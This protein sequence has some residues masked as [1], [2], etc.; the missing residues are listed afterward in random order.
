[1]KRRICLLL[2]AVLL[3]SLCGCGLSEPEPQGAER[4]SQEEPAC[5]LYA[6]YVDDHNAAGQLIRRT[7]LTVDGQ[8]EGWTQYEYDEDGRMAR[9]VHYS[10]AGAVQGWTSY[11]YNADGSRAAQFE[12]TAD[13]VLTQES[14]YRWDE[15]GYTLRVADYQNSIVT[16]IHEYDYDSEEQ[17]LRTAEYNAAG[18]ALSELLMEYDEDGRLSAKT[19]Y[20]KGVLRYAETYEYSAGKGRISQK[21]HRRA[22]GA[23]SVTVYDKWGIFLD[24]TWYNADDTLMTFD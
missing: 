23:Y 21:I 9:G 12:Y 11:E 2:T 1:M 13:E 10:A 15:N 4:D 24:E 17:L 22:D 20:E 5:I 16:G 18:V 3:I 19:Y 7:D 14:A 8:V 6:E